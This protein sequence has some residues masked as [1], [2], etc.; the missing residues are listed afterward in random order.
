MGVLEPII[1]VGTDI[2]SGS[3]SCFHVYFNKT[4]D[5][6]GVIHTVAKYGTKTT[7]SDTLSVTIN[8]R[9]VRIAFDSDYGYE[10]GKVGDSSLAWDTNFDTAISQCCLTHTPI[11]VG[12]ASGEY[13]D[14]ITYEISVA[15]YDY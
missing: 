8:S 2:T 11:Y 5:T 6:K 4:T 3:T 1:S 9:K 14:A 15:T 12:L 7:E 10:T 13:S